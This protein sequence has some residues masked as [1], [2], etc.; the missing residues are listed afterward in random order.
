[1]PLSQDQL[2]RWSHQEDTRTAITAHEV[3]RNAILGGQFTLRPPEI[4]LQGSYANDTNTFRDHDVDV[5]VQVNSNLLFRFNVDDLPFSDQEWLR[6]TVGP[7]TTTLESF[8]SDILRLLYQRFGHQNVTLGSKAVKVKGSPGY[9]LDADVVI[10]NQYRRYYS[11]NGNMDEG[12]IEGIYF[13][14]NAGNEIINYPKLHKAN[15]VRK[16]QET[17]N[18]FKPTVRV[19]KNARSHLVEHELLEGGVAPSYFI[20]GML[21]NVDTRI[22]QADHVQNFNSVLNWLVDNDDSWKYFKAQNGIDDL[23][24]ERSVQWD[25]VDAMKFLLA[26]L[27]LNN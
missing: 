3:I 10:C 26:L 18:L 6:R 2:E 1:V 21:Y 9:K 24:G 25:V 22:F 20:Q 27:K 4:F 15:G 13:T 12:F 16:H 8:R 19:F 11:F 7:A 14:D 23:F 17:G 5:V